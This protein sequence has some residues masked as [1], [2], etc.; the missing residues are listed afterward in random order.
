[1]ARVKKR[2]SKRRSRKISR[3][4]T[5]KRRSR[6]RLSK[7]NSKRR[8]RRK[9][10][11]RNSKRRSKKKNKKKMA[12]N[13]DGGAWGASHM[14]W[15]NDVNKYAK[16]FDAGVGEFT[17]S[18]SEFALGIRHRIEKNLE[19]K[20]ITGPIIKRIRAEALYRQAKREAAAEDRQ[21]KREAAAE[22]AAAAIKKEAAAWKKRLDAAP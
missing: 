4:K 13:Q 18:A 8:L 21:A 15:N 9:V 2:V 14:E 6:K 12:I 10:S 16:Q 19:G 1:M 7:R 5:S 17:D 20:K 3:K 22:E 11:K